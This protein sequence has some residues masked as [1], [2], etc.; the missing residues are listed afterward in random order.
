MYQVLICITHTIY[1]ISHQML[2]FALMVT[3]VFAGIKNS[4]SVG[5]RRPVYHIEPIESQL[6]SQDYSI[7]TSRQMSR[8][9][10]PEKLKVLFFD[11]ISVSQIGLHRE[12]KIHMLVLIICFFITSTK[13]KKS[14]HRIPVIL[15]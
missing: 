10:T 4:K 12:N 2:A 9:W 7:D 8:F 14:C 1:P 11:R 3:I 15:W 6:L 13:C 5:I